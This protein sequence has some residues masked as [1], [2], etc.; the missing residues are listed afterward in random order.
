MFGK[1][2]K[3]APTYVGPF[4]ILE[5]IGPVAYRLRLPEELSSMRDTFHVS[6]LKKLLADANLH[7]PLDEI[8][9]D[10][11]LRLVEDPI[12]IMERKVVDK[13]FK[14][15]TTSKKTQRNLLKQQYEIF[16]ASSSEMLDQTFD[17]LQ[18][19]ISQLE[20][21]GGSIS[22]ENDLQQIH[23]DD[24]E[25]IDLRW[26][27][28]MLT[29]RA[30]RFLKNIGRKFSLNE[31]KSLGFDKSK[32][33][34]YNCHK[35]GDFAREC[36]APRSQDT[37][38]RG[39]TR[40]TVSMEIPTSAALIIDKCKIGLGYNVA[41]PPYTGNFLPPK[42]NLS[43]LEEFVNKPIVSESTYKKPA[44]KTSEAKANK[45]KPKDVSKNLGPSLFEDWISDSEDEAE[46]KYKIE[47]ETVKSKEKDKGVIDSR[48]SWHMK[49]NMSYITYYEEI[50]GGYVAFG[51]NPKGG[52][53]TG[54]GNQS[55]D[56]AG[57]KECD[58]ADNVNTTNNVNAAGTNEVNDVGA[59][60]RNELPFDPEMPTLEGIST[61]NFSSD[62]EDDVEVADINNM[63]TTIQDERGIVIRNK[64]R[65]VAEGQIQEEGID[66]DEMDVKSAFLYGKIKEEVYVCQPLG[67]E[68]P[69]FLDKLYKFE[70][71]LYGV[72]QAPRAWY[73]TLSIYLLDNRFQ[74]GKID[75]TLFIRS[76]KVDILLIQVYVDDI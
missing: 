7:V 11:T 25:E 75:K 18:K 4:E 67:F 12:E 5:R 70:K 14:G 68:D 47:K 62:H 48:C 64:A 57:T 55:N 1:K 10:K 50:D 56:N 27:M 9:I 71:A 53:I 76:H 46:S 21:D 13:R 38:Y 58:D 34:C 61:F 51:G 2:G 42:P 52:K 23:P 49:R 41:P 26:Q 31:K 65:L 29:M 6:K 43:S 35:R 15:N 40:K 59:N 44:V 60:T 39:S 28:A 69:D 45:E 19:L 63:D 24:L 17:R 32:V 3:L 20:I 54:R 33:E 37:K 8:K 22:Q 30:M 72:Y 16:T 73:E 36:R 66:Y 74:R